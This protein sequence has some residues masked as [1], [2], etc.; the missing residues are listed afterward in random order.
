MTID[1]TSESLRLIGQFGDERF[2]SNRVEAVLLYR[3]Q[4]SNFGPH[5]EEGDYSY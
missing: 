4:A 3:C 1:Y 5:T 2:Y